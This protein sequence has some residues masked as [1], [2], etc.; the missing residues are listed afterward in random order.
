MSAMGIQQEELAEA[1]DYEKAHDLSLKTETSKVELE[2]IEDS[3][4]QLSEE[5]DQMDRELAEVRTQA[6]SLIADG[7]STLQEIQALISKGY[8]NTI[9]SA[10]DAHNQL[11][12][13]QSEG[14]KRIAELEELLEEK[15]GAVQQQ[16]EE[17]MNKVKSEAVDVFDE[18]EE[19]L[20][21]VAPLEEEIVALEQAL[22]RK[23]RLCPL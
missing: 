11:Q 23:R 12:Q 10:E 14:E 16:E 9:H 15:E 4:V 22:S 19:L 1:E 21:Q 3:V 20:V 8:D 17:V 13:K 2:A 6:I 7:V 18:R 5:G